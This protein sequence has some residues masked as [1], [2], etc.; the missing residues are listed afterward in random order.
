[1]TDDIVTRLRN[2]CVTGDNMWEVDVCDAMRGAA[3]EIVHLRSTI[4]LMKP[5]VPAELLERLEDSDD[6]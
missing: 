5:F 6:D 1:M 3:D 2:L 4:A